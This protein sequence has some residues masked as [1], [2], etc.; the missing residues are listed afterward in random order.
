A[1]APR[2]LVDEFVRDRVHERD[3]TGGGLEDAGGRLDDR[4]QHRGLDVGA[5][6]GR[7]DERLA[8]LLGQ[9]EAERVREG[10]AGRG[11]ALGQEL[12]AVAD[13]LLEA[14]GG[15]GDGGAER[16]WVAVDGR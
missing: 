1:G 13:A 2:G 9:W 14:V 11:A 16:R 15:A 3:R 6:D 7:L 5:V 4:R 12:E 10:G 8:L